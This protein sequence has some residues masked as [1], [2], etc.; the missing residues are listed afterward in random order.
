MIR[1]YDVCEERERPSPAYSA[2]DKPGSKELNCGIEAEL[3]AGMHGYSPRAADLSENAA[4]K[5]A[6]AAEHYRK[7][8]EQG[9]LSAMA[10]LVHLLSANLAA[11]AYDGESRDLIAR[12]EE[13]EI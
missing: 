2:A 3:W 12:L 10:H 5:M 7:A 8:A 6:E 13:A 11:E 9:N 4:L 1:C